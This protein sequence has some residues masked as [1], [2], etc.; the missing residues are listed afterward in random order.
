MKEPWTTGRI[1]R[2]ELF[3][4]EKIHYFWVIEFIHDFE[5]LNSYHKNN[6][7]VFAGI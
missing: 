3:L 2:K 5:T 7:Y 1:K 4:S 6:F